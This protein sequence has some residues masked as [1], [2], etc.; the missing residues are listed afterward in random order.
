MSCRA[1]PTLGLVFMLAR[2]GLTESRLSLVMLVAAVA[3][4]V[5]FQ[6]PNTANM[7]GY[8]AELL[9]HGLDIGYGDVR[10]RPGGAPFIPETREVIRRLEALAEV[11]QAVPLLT[12]PGAVGQGG[13]FHPM[14]VFGV[15]PGARYHP[16][17]LVE[18]ELLVEGDRGLLLGALLASRMG[19]RVGDEVHLRAIVSPA[20]DGLGDDGLGRFT[21]PVRGIVT[22]V[23]ASYQAAFVD[24]SLLSEEAGLRDASTMVLVYLHDH[25]QADH[26]ADRARELFPELQTRS[27]TED[28]RFLSSAISSI[29]AIGRVSEAMVVFAVAI[30]VLALLYINVLRRRRDVGVLCALGFARGEIFTIFAAQA[31]IVGLGG[32][33]IGSMLGLGLSWYFQAHPLFE[34]HG[35][36]I[37]PVLTVGAFLRPAAVVLGT[38]V[39]AGTYPAI[40]AARVDPA[41]VL[42]NVG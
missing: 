41:R 24:W 4:G 10:V 40:L 1:L 30:P 37:R 28:D 16:F 39:L 6:V 3:A 2:R 15:Q 9:V 35:F 12:F 32:V 20:D 34:Y 14:P 38:T 29:V 21:M 18:G 8:H 31:L 7:D 19:V 27:W 11:D 25:E 22:G 36:V 13:H 33:I 5:G 42:R 17:R 26:V 23:W